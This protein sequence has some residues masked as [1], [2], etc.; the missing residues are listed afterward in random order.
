MTL[1]SQHL[2]SGLPQST[3]LPVVTLAAQ[4]SYYLQIILTL[5]CCTSQA[6]KE[7]ERILVPLLLLEVE[8]GRK[9][10]KGVNSTKRGLLT[11]APLPLCPPPHGV[12]PS[13]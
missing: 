2:L 3:P 4:T 12:L 13:A 8:K 6:P 1:G 10:L 7:G 9:D 5:H 11:V